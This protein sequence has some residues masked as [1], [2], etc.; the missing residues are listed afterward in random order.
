MDNKIEK[1]AKAPK[2]SWRDLAKR[3]VEAVD[4]KECRVDIKHTKVRKIDK[5]QKFIIVKLKQKIPE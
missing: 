1:E 3:K 5:M 2:G 4:T